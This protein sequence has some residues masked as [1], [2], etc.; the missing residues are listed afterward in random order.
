[1][2]IQWSTTA[3]ASEAQGVKM[4]VYSDSGAGKT[5]M[6]ATLPRPVVI[7]AESGLLSLR[8]DNIARVYGANIAHISYD[9]PVA[10]V[11]T[12][13]QLYE[14]YQWLASTGRQHFLSVGMDSLTEIAE[15]VLANAKLGTKDPRQAYG[16]LI[17][18]MLRLVRMF[19]DL[20]GY[21]VYMSAK[22]E[23]SKDE[24]SGAMK[25]QPMMPGAKLGQ[26][27]PYFFDEVFHLGVARNAQGKAYRFL[28][29][30]LDM[31]YVAKDRSGSLDEIE[32]PDLT[33]VINKILGVKK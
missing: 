24:A 18:Q 26:Q 3:T 14:V 19:R 11:T 12:L 16:E 29:T 21:N 8:R 13:A 17:E 28:R 30:Q 20:P 7:S 31:Q 27:L 1:M 6:C 25:Y 23:F 22:M 4:L 15:V 32:M 9:I 5:V 33:H 10:Q 2:A